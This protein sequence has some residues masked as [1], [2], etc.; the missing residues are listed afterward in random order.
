MASPRIPKLAESYDDLIAGYYGRHHRERH[1][2]HHHLG[3]DQ[4]SPDQNS[5]DR[6]SPDRDSHGPGETAEATSGRSARVLS[7]TRDDGEILMQSRGRDVVVPAEG[8]DDDGNCF[9]SHDRRSPEYAIDAPPSALPA[10]SPQAAAPQAAS[11][12]SPAPALAAEPQ[13]SPAAEPPSA[14]TATPPELPA[15]TNGSGGPTPYTMPPPSPVTS[16][17]VEEHEL[18]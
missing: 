14:P 12:P 13:T 1:H 2:H 15:S 7:L 6:D 5:P 16:S 3:L 11:P 9:G 18:A 10:A 8:G 4:N 17:S